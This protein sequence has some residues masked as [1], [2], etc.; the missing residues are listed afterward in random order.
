M[1]ILQLSD[2]KRQ[3]YNTLADIAALQSQ[4]SHGLE[5]EYPRK[6]KKKEEKQIQT[7]NDLTLLT[8]VVPAHIHIGNIILDCN[9]LFGS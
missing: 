1:A 6:E 4:S 5:N 7:Q 2:N 3:T 8:K 9:I